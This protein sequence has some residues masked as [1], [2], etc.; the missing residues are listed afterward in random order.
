MKTCYTFLVVLIISCGTANTK[1]EEKIFPIP[2]YSASQNNPSANLHKAGDVEVFRLISKDTFYFT[3]MYRKENGEV[4]AYETTITG[5]NSYDN[6]NYNW[7]NDSTIVF[8]LIDTKNN[9]TQ[10]IQLMGSGAVTTVQ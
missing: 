3:R 10:S 5:H 9:K 4:R 2:S 7:L 8:K 6:M 1:S